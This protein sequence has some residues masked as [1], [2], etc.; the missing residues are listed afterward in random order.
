MTQIK[1]FFIA[2]LFLGLFSCSE[3]KVTKAS[4]KSVEID[5][6]ITNN[7]VAEDLITPY[8]ASLESSMNE[9]I[10]TCVQDLLTGCPEGRLGN[11]CADL[12]QQRALSWCK[13]KKDVALPQFSVLNNGGL[14]VPLLKGPIK[15]SNIYELMPFE[16]E[17]VIV[18]LTGEKMAE[19]IAYVASKSKEKGRKAGVPI[20]EPFELIID[21]TETETDCFINGTAFDPQ[22]NYVVATT[23]YLANGG[24][25]MKFFLHPVSIIKT[26]VKL[27][28]AIL[29][30][31]RS[32]QQK[33]QMVDAKLTGRVR[34]E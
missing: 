25:K 32:L 10:N 18:T 33:G 3:L 22:K 6:S 17:I 4:G 26:G 24:D 8:K 13:A 19:L 2:I 1:S 21:T 30:H 34:Y 12:T 29:D 14:R 27:R 15:V 28:D 16:N 31:V 20:S 5:N 9:K 7:K 11:F 23:D